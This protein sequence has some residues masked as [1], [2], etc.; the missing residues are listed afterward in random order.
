[1]GMESIAEELRD[2]DA[3]AQTSALDIGSMVFEDRSVL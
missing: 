1:M 2:M 3:H